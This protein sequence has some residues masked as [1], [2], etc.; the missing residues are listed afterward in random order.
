MS[1]LA[2]V[3][4]FFRPAYPARR[5]AALRILIGAYGGLYVAAQAY[6]FARLAKARPTDFAPTG[7]LRILDSP[8]PAWALYASIGATIAAS[9]PFVLGYRYRLFGPLFAAL[10]LWTTTYHNAFGMVFHTE[11]LTALHL[12]VLALADASAAWSLD[13]RRRGAPMLED[14]PRFGW[15]VRLLSMVTVST[16][17]LAGVAKLRISGG[18]WVSGDILVHQI[19][20]DNLRKAALGDTYSPLGVFVVR[21]AWLLKPLAAASVAI[22]LGAPLAL[23][24]PRAAKVWAVCAWGFHAG[25][26]ALMAIFFP[27]PMLGLAMLSLLPAERV[28]ERAQAVLARVRRRP[29]PS[30]AA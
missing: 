22:E 3:D 10:F 4:R 7:V 23:V 20:Y 9:V 15:P 5:L 29:A 24:G 11:N 25:V 16:Y 26:F 19:A 17:V 2:A 28:I 12:V 14:A 30:A 13:A 21:H 6:P 27:Y 8:M 1:P 18:E